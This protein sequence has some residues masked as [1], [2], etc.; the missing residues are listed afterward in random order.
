MYLWKILFIW[1]E[2]CESVYNFQH[3][4]ELVVSTFSVFQEQMDTARSSNTLTPI[5][6]WVCCYTPETV[7]LMS[8]TVRTPNN[9]EVFVLMRKWSLEFKEHLL[10]PL[11]FL[12]LSNFILLMATSSQTIYVYNVWSFT[13]VRN[14]TPV[15]QWGSLLEG[16]QSMFHVLIYGFTYLKAVPF[17]IYIKKEK[18]FYHA[19]AWY[20]LFYFPLHIL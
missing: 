13:N 7:F 6:Q 3:L 19:Q 8:T 5:H 10:K 4:E 17:L 18:I 16:G 2:T 12:T 15:K 14:F 20:K 1:D 11:N 9:T